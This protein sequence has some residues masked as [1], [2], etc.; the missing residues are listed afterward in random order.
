[1]HELGVLKFSHIVVVCRDASLALDRVN[2]PVDFVT[3]VRGEGFVDPCLVVPD[4]AV[5]WIEV[6]ITVV[7]FE[8]MGAL[9]LWGLGKISVEH[10][11]VFKSPIQREEIDT[12]LLGVCGRPQCCSQSRKPR[13]NLHVDVAAETVPVDCVLKRNAFAGFPT[14]R[15]DRSARPVDSIVQKCLKQRRA[16]LDARHRMNVRS[17]ELPMS[18]FVI[19]QKFIADETS[20]CRNVVI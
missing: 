10:G 7:H 3:G 13:A 14:E 6:E 1:M 19:E 20:D 12:A 16:F 17:R 4:D 8:Q 18:F 9:V 11:F 15:A 5:V 2:S